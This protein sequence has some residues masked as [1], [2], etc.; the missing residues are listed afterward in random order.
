MNII[1]N[2][3]KGQI[4]PGKGLDRK[5]I[6]MKIASNNFKK[7]QIQ[8]KITILQIKSYLQLY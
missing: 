8:F 3:K 2:Y 5:L 4:H 6:Y 7:N 1:L